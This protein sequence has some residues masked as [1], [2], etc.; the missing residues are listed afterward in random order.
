MKARKKQTSAASKRPTN[1]MPPRVTQVI[2]MAARFD[3]SISVPT[4][5]TLFRFE[6]G[7]P[8]GKAQV[9]IAKLFGAEYAYL[10]TNGTTPL[11]VIAILSMVYPGEAILLQRDSH[12]SILAPVIHAGLK[13]L[14]IRPAYSQ[15]LG[16]TL[17]ITAEQL[18]KALQEHPE[19][20]LVV[21]TIPN[22]F[23]IT[24]D[25]AALVDAARRMGV[26]V[27][28]DSAHGSH[29]VFYDRFPIRAETVG[30]T[31]VTYSTHK[32]SPALGQGSVMMINDAA[33][34]KRAYEV[35][36]NLGFVSTSFSSV[37]LMGLV[38]GIFMM[39][40]NGPSILQERMDMASWARSEINKIDGM[41]VFGREEAQAGFLDLDPL[42]I[43]VGTLEA[44]RT[45]YAVERIL[46][47]S[48]QIYPEMATL[49]NVLFL[50][51]PGVGWRD[52][53]R[54]VAGL[55][56]IAR[57]GARKRIR[58]MQDTPE[59]PSQVMLPRDAFYFRQR[60]RIPVAEAAGL[61]SAETI[62]AYPPGSAIIV[63]GE[64]LTQEVLTYLQG[65]QR[66]GGHLKGAQDARFR[67]VEILDV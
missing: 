57:V 25:T 54:M 45:G 62:S 2:R 27:M 39:A 41:H 35:V 63:A 67:T 18:I 12:V 53:R 31:A 58:Q 29:W 14:Y 43:T 56:E 23:G 55:R 15:R 33:V 42:R 59:L 9:S 22:Y 3:H 47:E 48:Y 44:G 38:H 37:I 34:F 66:A 16:V 21:L 1:D 17:G 10:S 60:R 64:I 11:N 6:P 30:A 40:R 8:I 61:I 65:I 28:V 24:A 51:T 4:W 26:A 13:P 50:I 19:I 46:N 49:Q 36:N 7:E 52:V 5:G 32:T 20:R